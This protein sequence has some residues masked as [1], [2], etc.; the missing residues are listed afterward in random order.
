[1]LAEI[2]RRIP[3]PSAEQWREIHK[4]FWRTGI[5]GYFSGW[6]SGSMAADLNAVSAFADGWSD[7]ITAPVAAP[8]ATLWTTR[9]FRLNNAHAKILALILAYQNPVDFLTGQK[10]DVH[11]ALAWQNSKEFHHIFPQAHLKKAGIAGPQASALANMAYLSSASNKQISDK[12]PATYFKELLDKH[13]AIAR[14]WLATNLIDDDAISAALAN[15]YDA[16]LKAR[17][18]RINTVARQLAGW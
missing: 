2:F 17:S 16:F 13:G 9:T 18:Q 4:W 5:G 11:E 15:D 6:N 3:N 12:A 7:D 14:G 1:V 8:P 10:I